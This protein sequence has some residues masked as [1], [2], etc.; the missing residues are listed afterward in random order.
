[1]AE[2]LKL[3]RE[4]LGLNQQKAAQALGFKHYQTLSDIE[5]GKRTVKVAEL[6]RFAEVYGRSLDFFLAVS[7]PM[8][9][10]VVRWRNGGDSLAAKKA[11]RRFLQYC[12]DYVRLEELSGHKS[13]TIPPVDV[14]SVA[15]FEE[16]EKLAERIWGLMELGS[17]PALELQVVLEERFG[18]KILV[19]DTEGGGS[20]ACTKGHFGVGILINA[21]DAPWRRNYDIAH[22]LYHLLTWEVQP[23]LGSLSHQ[24]PISEQYADKFASTLLLQ[25]RS[26]REEFKRRRHPD[27]LS[28][29]DAIAMAREFGVSTEALLWRLV[30][31][32]LL[33]RDSVQQA[34]KSATLRQL[35]RAERKS[36]WP[37]VG[38]PAHSL[39]FV[40]LAFECL[41]LGAISRGKFAQ[42]MGIPRGEIAAFLASYGFDESR[43]YFGQISAT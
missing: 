8:E 14:Q 15:T 21:T 37:T 6:A 2:R 25:E 40:S 16:V 9:Q 20:A 4:E 29:P 23:G 12:E 11:E 36:D 17:R 30:G 19:M 1:V 27:G 41:Q 39:R 43:D 35:D 42:L 10:P 13:G 31:L 32:G 3:A 22:E 28:Y 26:V 7:R 38:R 33:K 5:N 34:L 24:K 18:V